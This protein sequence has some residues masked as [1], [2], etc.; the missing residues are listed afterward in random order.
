MIAD[1]A[2]MSLMQRS[3]LK[4]LSKDIL[5]ATPEEADDDYGDELGGYG[6]YY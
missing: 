4:K 3:L 6:M 1:H 2:E 5:P